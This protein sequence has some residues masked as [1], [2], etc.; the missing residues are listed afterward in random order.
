MED[1]RPKRGARPKFTHLEDLQLRM[2]VKK[3]G[4]RNWNKISRKMIGKT[5]MQ[6]RNRWVNYSDPNLNQDDWA[7]SEDALLVDKY[8]EFGPRWTIIS[9]FFN[10]RSVLAIRNRFLKLNRAGMVDKQYIKKQNQLKTE[11]KTVVDDLPE[12]IQKEEQHVIITPIRQDTIQCKF[13]II[14]IKSLLN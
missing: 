10:H 8:I 4:T 1:E 3:Y 14:D 7:S 11:K 5:A 9:K 6:C 13:D 2:L 12:V